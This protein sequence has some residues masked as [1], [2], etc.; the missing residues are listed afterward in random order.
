MCEL[1]ALRRL[2][3]HL[4]YA[5]Y[6][7]ETPFRSN[8]AIALP[9]SPLQMNGSID[10]N[11]ATLNPAPDTSSETRAVAS[12]SDMPSIAATAFNCDT[13]NVAV[14]VWVLGLP[15]KKENY[16]CVEIYF[17]WVEKYPMKTI[18]NFPPKKT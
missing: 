17:K 12:F 9:S 8:S 3:V 1:P 6:E 5:F 11:L 4:F 15:I 2:L 7:I 10:A 13:A 16:D 14:N 18:A